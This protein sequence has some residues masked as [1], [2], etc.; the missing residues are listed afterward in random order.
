MEEGGPLGSGPL[1][2][3]RVVPGLLRHLGALDD[4]CCGST[5]LPEPAAA[6]APRRSPAGLAPEM[7]MLHRHCGACHERAE[8]FPPGFLAGEGEGL[9]RRVAVCAPRM[10]YRMAM[11]AVPEARRTKTP[12]PPPAGAHVAGFAESADYRALMA[13]LPTLAG[14][15]LEALLQSPYADLPACRPAFD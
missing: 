8:R 6:D 5:R 4:R 9:R 13:W 3:R 14:Q 12:M 1:N 7:A 11:G 10:A 2:R 15:S